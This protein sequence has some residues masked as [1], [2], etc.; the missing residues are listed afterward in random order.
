[1]TLPRW[2]YIHSCGKPAFYATELPAHFA[3]ITS[4]NMFHLDGKPI[5]LGSPCACDSCNESI[6][7]TM[8][9]IKNFK[10]SESK[11]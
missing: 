3:L 11:S 7:T 6:N 1:M 4:K 5:E 8:M 10:L 2:E 9:R